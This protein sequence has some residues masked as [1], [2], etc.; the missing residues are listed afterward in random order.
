[1]IVKNIKL[2]ISVCDSQ[3]ILPVFP[4]KKNQH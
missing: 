3:L 4:I 1:M 2:S